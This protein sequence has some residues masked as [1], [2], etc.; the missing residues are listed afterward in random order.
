MMNWQQLF[1]N[2]RLSHFRKEEIQSTSPERNA[3]QRDFDRIVFSS[4]FR[5]LQNKTQVFPLP[6][7]VFI[8]NRLTHSLE[9]ASVGRSL[10]K[11]VGE[12]IA[13]KYNADEEFTEFYKYDLANVIAAACL[14]HDIGNPP[15]GH[16]GEYAIRNFFKSLQ[17]AQRQK[18]ETEL[19]LNQQRDFEYFEGNSNT[20]RLLSQAQSHSTSTFDLTI[21]TLAAIVKYPCDAVSG[22]NKNTVNIATKKSGWF[23]AE[24]ESYQLI[25]KKLGIPATS[26]HATVYTR[27]P[28]VFLTEAADDI[29]Y[30]VIDMEDAHRLG[31]VSIEKICDMFL[32]FFKSNSKYF[33]LD[34][35]E[36]KLKTIEDDNQ[37]MQY[38]RAVWIGNMTNQMAD[39]FMENE[40]ALL[41]GMVQKSLLELLPEEQLKLLHEINHFSVKY[42]YNYK[43]VVEIEIAGFKVLDELLKLFVSAVM[44]PSELKSKKLFLLIPKQF[45]VGEDGNSLYDNLM[46]ITDFISGMTDLYAVDLYKKMKGI[47]IAKL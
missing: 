37:K 29:C 23:D 22:F 39:I 13:E 5:R 47:E 42:I 46:G 21:T 45:K 33:S 18:F 11:M 25:A 28:Y 17:G 2:R 27:H 24:K 20:F 9:V 6:G 15:F 34:K 19:S 31:I 44:Q 38:L 3:F 40:T 8:H 30:R 7:A 36:R 1:D 43:P 14:A 10:G 41:E 35:I 26:E 32:P 12:K 16:Y 4:A